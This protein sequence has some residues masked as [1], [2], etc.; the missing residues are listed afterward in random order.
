LL[1]EELEIEHELTIRFNLGI[2]RKNFI[3]YYCMYKMTLHINGGLPVG[4]SVIQK[5]SDKC[6]PR[7]FVN[8]TLW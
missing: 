3:Q 5:A 2:A 6:C 8:R 1:P 7:T 4:I